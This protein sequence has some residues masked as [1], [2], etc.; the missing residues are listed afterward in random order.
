[1]SNEFKTTINHDEIKRWVEM[2]RGRPQII[3]APDAT[4]DQVS[5]RID[6]PGKEDERYGVSDWAKYVTW[7]EFFEVFERQ[8]L[9]FSYSEDRD[10]EDFSRAYRF[11]KRERVINNF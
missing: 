10:I 11:I 8:K 3:D 7:D 9:A 5:I 2:R 4:G 6:F 1:M